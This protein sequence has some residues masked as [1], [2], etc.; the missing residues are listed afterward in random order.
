[1][2]DLGSIT[3]NDIITWGA[4]LSALVVYTKNATRPIKDFTDRVS[5]IERNQ[6]NDN[7]RLKDLET[8]S[9]LTLKAICLMLEERIANDDKDGKLAKI[10]D[11][12]DEYLYN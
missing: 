6:D 7:K 5:K 9:K 4:I 11:D 10:K 3:I 1:M 2:T 8:C 12:I